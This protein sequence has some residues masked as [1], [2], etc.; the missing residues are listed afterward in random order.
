MRLFVGN[1]SKSTRVSDLEVEFEKYGRCKV[2][3]PKVQ[4]SSTRPPNSSTS[5]LAR[6]SF[7]AAL[8]SVC[9]FT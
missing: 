8:P 6:L 1:L 2:K 9:P 4:P 7:R 3:I 5:S